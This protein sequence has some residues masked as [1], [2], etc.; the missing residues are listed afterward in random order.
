MAG[1]ETENFSFYLARYTFATLSL[2][3]GA[4][5]REI[6]EGL[7]HS[8]ISITE[9][10]LEGFADSELDDIFEKRLKKL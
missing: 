2:R 8:D 10:Y 9:T 6:M 7:G 1:I 3:K 4:S 5:T